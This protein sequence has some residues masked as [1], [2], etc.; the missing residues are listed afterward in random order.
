VGFAAADIAAGMYA[1][2]GILAALVRREQTGMGASIEISMLDCLAEW[3]SAQLY[4]AHYSGTQPPRTGRRH[5]GIAPYGTFRLS[6]GRTILLAV[7]NDRE[8][9]A[10]TQHVLGDSSLADDRRFRTNPDRI[11][12]VIAVEALVADALA[13][14]DDSEALSRLSAAGIATAGVNDLDTVWEH[15]QL[16]ARDRFIE[17]GSPV[18]PLEMLAAPFGFGPQIAASIPDVGEHDG[19]VIADVIA[20]GR[21]RR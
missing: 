15:P 13:A 6:S 11:D 4:S 20:R 17:V 1:L 21:E 19:D 9:A 7:Q 14:V 12:H 8:W 3:L 5:P 10:L 18:G 16:R 2:T